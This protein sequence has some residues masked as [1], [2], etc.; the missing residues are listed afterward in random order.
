[1]ADPSYT[2][3]LFAKASDE[4]AR[5]IHHKLM[6][7]V[8]VAC[9]TVI[10]RVAL[11]HF[12]R[13]TL[14]WTEVL[15][16][17][18]II[19]GSFGI[20]LLGAFIVNLFRA[21]PLLDRKRSEEN[22][23]LIERLNVAERSAEL[24][25]QRHTGGDIRGTIKRGYVDLRTFSDSNTGG[26]WIILPRGCLVQFYIESVNHND[27]ATWFKAPE[28]KLEL[29]IGKACFYGMWQRVSHSL[30]IRDDTVNNKRL[31]DIFENPILSFNRPLQQGI[32]WNGYVGFLIPDF[33]RALL[34]G[35]TDMSAS[36]KILI[37][38]TLDKVH[39]VENDIK[40]L[41]GRLC[42]ITEIGSQ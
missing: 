29:C 11:W 34:E 10:V 6:T 35:K 20:V 5:F 30:A 36:V 32:P 1:M 8:A 26:D 7:G 16:N 21:P 42:F 28:T 38:D 33:D 23:A 12:H 9:A 40:L 17:L 19:A 4:T 25:R 3:R 15:I 22:A 18:L 27:Q 14:T 39:R 2:C 13:I 37:V 24:E 31:A 41:I